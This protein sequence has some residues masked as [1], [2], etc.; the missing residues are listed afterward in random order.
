MTSPTTITT[1]LRLKKC[2][3]VHKLYNMLNNKQIT[4]LICWAETPPANTFLI[5]PNKE[6]SEALSTYFKHGNVASFVRQLHIYGFHK[7]LDSSAGLKK[8]HPVWEFRHSS[9]KFRKNDEA[10]LAFIKRRLQLSSLSLKHEMP[11]HRRNSHFFEMPH[12][13]HKTN[14]QVFYTTAGMNR[15]QYDIKY[16]SV[17]PHHSFEKFAGMPDRSDV[18][19]VSQMPNVYHGLPPS[20]VKQI[21][22][23]FPGPVYYLAP[24]M[25]SVSGHLSH[26]SLVQPLQHPVLQQRQLPQPQVMSQQYICANGPMAMQPVYPG[27]SQTSSPGYLQT[28]SVPVPMAHVGR[29]PVVELQGKAQGYLPVHW[30]GPGG[31]AVTHKQSSPSSQ[32]ESQESRP[33]AFVQLRKPSSIALSISTTAGHAFSESPAEESAGTKSNETGNTAA[34][35]RSFPAQ[36]TWGHNLAPAEQHIALPP[37]REPSGA[38]VTL[39][40]TSEKFSYDMQGGNAQSVP[41]TAGKGTNGAT[42][43][44]SSKTPRMPLSLPPIL[45]KLLLQPVSPPRTSNCESCSENGSETNTAAAAA[46]KAV[47]SG[48]LETIQGKCSAAKTETKRS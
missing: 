35:A 29:A 38:V 17:S 36:Y 4:H 11:L 28:G 19:V 18:R 13:A 9:G 40:P 48:D 7:V 8:K 6:F 31:S 41:A 2:S 1:D 47:S 42:D 24:G 3:F 30:Q 43:A 16:V 34:N 32:Q 26:P 14:G 27:P 37:I 12:S 20:M 22:K 33:Q 44:P 10:S 45:P 15:H 46:Q 5:R 25:V 39:P 23:S 21:G